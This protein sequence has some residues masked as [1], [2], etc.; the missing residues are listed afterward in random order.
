ML[1]IR[2]PICLEAV[3][4]NA[5]RLQ[6]THLYH[7]QCYRQW[8]QQNRSCPICRHRA[9]PQE[10]DLAP[11]PHVSEIIVQVCD[12]NC[13]HSETV[14]MIYTCHAF[15]Y[16]YIHSMY[17]YSQIHTVYTALFYCFNFCNF[18]P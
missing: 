16:I 12:S 5:V 14:N 15:I 18:R 2:C 8:I 1:I 11:P 10:V 9:I 6:C 7:Y 13:V 4:N 17:V 3:W